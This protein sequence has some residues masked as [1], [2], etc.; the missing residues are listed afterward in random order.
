M[1]QPS[2][3]DQTQREKAQCLLTKHTPEIFGAKWF[4]SLGWCFKTYHIQDIG[5]IWAWTTNDWELLAADRS[6]VAYDDYSL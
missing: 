6:S 3:V 2:L 4:Q 1:P 5:W